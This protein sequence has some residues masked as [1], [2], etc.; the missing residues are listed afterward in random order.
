MSLIKHIVVWLLKLIGL[1]Y[2]AHVN[3]RTY[4]VWAGWW[5]QRIHRLAARIQLQGKIQELQQ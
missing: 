4:I 5:W 3:D 2:T 1:V